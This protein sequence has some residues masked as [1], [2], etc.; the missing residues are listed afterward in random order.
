MGLALFGFPIP[1]DARTP[2][3]IAEWVAGTTSI[4]GHGRNF[5]EMAE[6]GRFNCFPY[7][8]KGFPPQLGEVV[9]TTCRPDPKRQLSLD[10]V[11]GMVEGGQSITLLFGIGP[12]G[13]PKD[14]MRI[15]R[16]N[17]DITPG[18]FSLETATALGAVCGA[19]AARLGKIRSR[20]VPAL[21]GLHALLDDALPAGVDYRVV[22]P[23][24]DV[25]EAGSFVEYPLDLVHVYAPA[26]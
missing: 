24:L 20:R 3:Q 17:L 8:G 6:T 2:M 11:A 1:E 16:Y 21:E 22:E 12:H 5:L 19:L 7:P 4:G 14:V 23:V 9:L 13:V 26:E 10:E 25:R 18:G 15:P